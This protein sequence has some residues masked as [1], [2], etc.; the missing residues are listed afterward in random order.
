MKIRLFY[1]YCPEVSR[2]LVHF[3]RTVA[4]GEQAS[5][6]AVNGQCVANSVPKDN[7]EGWYHCTN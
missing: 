1:N 4:G 3:P 2:D 6:V 7:N 5:L